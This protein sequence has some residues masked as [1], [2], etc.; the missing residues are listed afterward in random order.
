MRSA[1]STWRSVWPSWATELS[2][3][4]N[5]LGKS[6]ALALSPPEPL[7]VGVTDSVG[8]PHP[9]SAAPQRTSEPASVSRINLGW[10]DIKSSAALGRSLLKVVFNEGVA[11]LKTSFNINLRPGNGAFKPKLAQD[12]GASPSAN[13]YERCGMP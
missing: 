5:A 9:R 6:Y 11:Q 4:T 8:V 10:I 2:L 3:G 12:V 7:V 1:T 13:S